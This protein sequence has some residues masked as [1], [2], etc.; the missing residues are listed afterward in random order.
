MLGLVVV[1][2]NEGG[3]FPVIIYCYGDMEM[4]Y[5]EFFRSRFSE[6]DIISGKLYKHNNI[7]RL[8]KLERLKGKV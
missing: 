8:L 5:N 2:N 1:I 3:V 4:L 7:D 6:M